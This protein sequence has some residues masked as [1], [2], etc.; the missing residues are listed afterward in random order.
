[1]EAAFSTASPIIC[2]RFLADLTAKVAGV[3]P[4]QSDPVADFRVAKT[5]RLVG[6][7]IQ[8]TLLHCAYLEWAHTNGGAGLSARRLAK[9]LHALGLKSIKSSVIVWLDIELL[10]R[11]R[12][13]A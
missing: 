10:S 4:R 13:A 11:T 8:S 9:S 1:L 6:A 7:R 2:E 3:G 12:A 5:R